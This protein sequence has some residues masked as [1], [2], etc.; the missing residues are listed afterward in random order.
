MLNH[1]S[2]T[3]MCK[4]HTICV[5]MS[6]RQRTSHKALASCCTDSLYLAKP[7]LQIIHIKVVDFKSVRDLHD[8]HCEKQRAAFHH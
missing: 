4:H 7:K 1:S 2:R 5:H 8:T 3:Q 6:Y